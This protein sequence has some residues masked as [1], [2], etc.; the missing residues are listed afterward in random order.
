MFIVLKRKKIVVILLVLIVAQMCLT[1]YLC[2][3]QLEAKNTSIIDFTVVI[4]AGHGGIDGGVVAKNGVKES[5]LNLAYAK[6]LGA[7][8]E[9]GGFHVVQTRKT[10]DGLYGLPT[11]GFKL[12]DMKARKEIIANAGPDLVISIHMNKF[13]QSTRSGPQVFYQQGKQSGQTLA[14]SL[15]K[16]FNDFTGNSH[17]AIAGDYFICRE[18]DCPA[19]IVEC[20]FLSN[21]EDA[22]NLQTD[23]YKERLCNFIYQGI[24][25]YLYETE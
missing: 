15:Q 24:M 12:R 1:A 7:F 16:V 11:K 4:D 6:T 21:D 19:V 23:V 13:S 8:F 10:E 2:A 17:E 25:L 5:N 14:K 18:I 22:E 9:Q 20:G 3:K